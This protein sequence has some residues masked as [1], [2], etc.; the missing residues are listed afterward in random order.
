MR[1]IGEGSLSS[2]ESQYNAK[3]EAAGGMQDCVKLFRRCNFMKI[4]GRRNSGTH[5]TIQ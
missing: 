1:W 3:G 2:L 5:E 4:C